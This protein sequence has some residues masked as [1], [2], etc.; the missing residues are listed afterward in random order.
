MRVGFTMQIAAFFPQSLTAW[1]GRKSSVVY[2][3]GCNFECKY[4]YAHSIIADSENLETIPQEKILQELFNGFPE[5]NSVVISGGEP[6]LQGKKLVE[7]LQVLKAEGFEVKLDTN[8]SDSVL[9]EEILGKGLVDFVSIDLKSQINDYS[10]FKITGKRVNIEEVWRSIQATKFYCNDYEFRMTFVPALHSHRDV[11]ELSRQ[12]KGAKRFVLQQFIG[13][14]GTLGKEVEGCPSPSYEKLLKT[15][16]QIQGIE[17]VRI[18]TMKGD[19]IISPIMQKAG[20][21]L[22]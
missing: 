5:V 19:E 15:A 13:S 3:P 20:R 11:L 1:P 14:E 21:I 22:F 7:F 8:G 6:L 4:C 12:L 9:L 2:A 17:E 16:R 18:R 10:Y